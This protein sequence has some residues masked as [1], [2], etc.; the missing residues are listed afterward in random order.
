[1]S[2]LSKEK[3]QCETLASHTLNLIIFIV[4]YNRQIYMFIV[5]TIIFI[6]AKFLDH[7]GSR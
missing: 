7:E 5:V 3:T 4:T 1:M 6:G 2:Y